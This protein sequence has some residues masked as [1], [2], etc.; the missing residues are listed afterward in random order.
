MKVIYHVEARYPWAPGRED[1]D[2]ILDLEADD[3]PPNVKREMGCGLDFDAFYH[4]EH[5]GID[6]WWWV[7]PA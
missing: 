6:L 4:W 1:T 2:T 7:R 3:L 5:L